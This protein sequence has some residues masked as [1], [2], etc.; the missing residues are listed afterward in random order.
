M[1][2]LKILLNPTHSDP[3]QAKFSQFINA[4]VLISTWSAAASDIY[5]SSRFLF[6]L[7]RCKHAPHFFASLIKYP[8]TPA[9]GSREDV[10]IDSQPL[11]QGQDTP[12]L[13]G[14]NEEGANIADRDESTG[15]W[16]S[17]G[18]S[19]EVSELRSPSEREL[20]ASADVENAT[21][22]PT[23]RQP[24]LV[25]PLYAV[26]GSASIGFL[27]FLNRRGVGNTSAE[28]VCDTLT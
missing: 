18:I 10:A 8:S 6:F 24:W 11:M 17:G 3:Q 9:T 1:Y 21:M 16:E 7:A 13:H 15:S 19:V 20:A 28:T 27:S 4:A 2:V 14:N 22:V 25:L 26:L 5:I 12:S 23:Q